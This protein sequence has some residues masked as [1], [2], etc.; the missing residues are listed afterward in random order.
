MV[1]TSLQAQ[2]RIHR[3]NHININKTVHMAD[4]NYVLRPFEGNINTGDPTGIKLYIQ[5]TKDIENETHKL[6]IPLSNAKDIVDHFIS[7]AK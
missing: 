2:T 1:F 3:F 5:L 7:L 4:V 6:D